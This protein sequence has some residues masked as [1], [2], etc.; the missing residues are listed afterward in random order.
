MPRYYKVMGVKGHL[1]GS[2]TQGDARGFVAQSK[3]SREKLDELRKTKG[4][5]DMADM[6]EPREDVVEEEAGV[7]AAMKLGELK[8]L[9]DPIVAPSLAAARAAFAGPVK[10][11]KKEGSK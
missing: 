7:M 10:P 8:K 9:A 3:M 1:V 5:L 11:E 2:P 6:Y 4:A